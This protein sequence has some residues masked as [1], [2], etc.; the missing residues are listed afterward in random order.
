MKIGI[1]YCTSDT[2]QTGRELE[3]LAD[4]EILEVAGAVHEA[5]ERQGHRTEE[6]DLR[7]HPLEDLCQFN[8]IFNL[9]ET[10]YGF[11]LK[12]YEITSAIE[13]MGIP[14]TGCSSKVLKSC[15]DKSLTKSILRKRNLLTP[16]YEVLK[17][18]ERI[19]SRLGFPLIVKPMKEDGSVGISKN[20][21]VTSL[22]SLSEKVKEIHAAYHQ[23]ALV[24]EYLEGRDISVAI[25]GSRESPQVLPPAE[26][27]F[28]P[29]YEGARIQTFE[30]KWLVDSADYQN[31][32]TACPCELDD[33]LL[34]QIEETCIK[35]Y[36]ILGCRD[37]AR[38]DL[39]L[40]DHSP[41]IIE[42]NPN[43]CIN[44]HDS[45]F[46]RAGKVAGYSY[47]DLIHIILSS[48]IVNWKYPIPISSGVSY[49]R[50]IE[51]TRSGRSS[52]D[53]QIITPN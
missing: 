13:A 45:G 28:Q 4:L 6:V 18:G 1:V 5:L 38:V 50:F 47:D 40:L 46:V 48:S 22:E 34:K 41:Y 15:N 37:Y 43:P 12:D 11:P 7:I 14:F 24:E 49:G 30:S 39:R 2:I 36:R 23:P 10:V 52:G 19:T 29:S 53:Y 17:P 32:Y 16:R 26:C 27:V 44:P 8:W 51:K 33:E 21:V 25:L 3:K 20:S 42:V 35:A 31:A 9:V